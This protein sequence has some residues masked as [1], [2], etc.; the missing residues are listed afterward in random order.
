MTSKFNKDMYAKIKAKKNE[1]LSSIGQKT[2]RII[3]KEKEREKEVAERGS[4]T[5]TL[6]ERWTAS[7]VVSLEEVP[8]VKKQK[9]GYKG[10]EKVGSTIWADAEAAMT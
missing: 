2:L 1:P 9:T 3:D 7:P 10:K 5:P 6:E 8:T 4:S